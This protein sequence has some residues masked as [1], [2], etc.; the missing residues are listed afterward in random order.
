MEK[1][2]ALLEPELLFTKVYKENRHLPKAARE[3]ACLKVQ[4]KT[5]LR[6]IKPYQKVAGYIKFNDVG[7]YHVM[8]GG[9]TE[10]ID[11]AGFCY[12]KGNILKKLNSGN[13]TTQKKQEVLD[14]CA[15]WDGEYTNFKA[16]QNFTDDM[17]AVA[18]TDK[19]ESESAV[20]HPLYRVAEMQLNWQKLVKFGIGGLKNEVKEKLAVGSCQLSGDFYKELLGVLNLFDEACLFYIE[21]AEAKGRNEIKTALQNIRHNPPETFFEVLQLIWLYSVCAGA[22]DFN[23][24]DVVLGDFYYND[25]QKGTLFEQDAVEM[26][27]SAFRCIQE[28]YGRN[29]RITF[30]GLGRRNEKNADALALVIMEAGRRAHV[31]F[32]QLSLRMYKGMNG[33]L[34]DKALELLS[35]GLTLPVLYNDDKNIG[36]VAKAFEVSQEVATDY[37]FLGCGEYLLAHR[38]IGTPNVII[39]MAK[40]LE[41]VINENAGN[42]NLTFCELWQAYEKKTE[43]F[44]RGAARIQESIYKTLNNEVS[45]LFQSLLMDDCVARGKAVLD[46]GIWHLGGTIETYGNITVSDSLYAIKKAVYK[47]KAITLSELF[48]MLKCNFEGYEKQ[49]QYLLNLHKYG[50]GHSEV[51]AMAAKVHEHMCLL[52]KSQNKNTSLSSFLVVEINNSANVTLG[53]YVGATANGRLAEDCLSNGNN[54]TKGA[55]KNGITALIHSLTKMRGDIHAGITQNFKFSK[56]FFDNDRDNLKTVLKTYFL[57]GG[58]QANINVLNKNDLQNAIKNPA[59]HQNLF[60]RVGGYSARFVDLPSDVQKD[61]IERTLY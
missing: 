15:F 33:K 4:L 50:N 2:Y 11:K 6:G 3:V 36:D 59:E 54:P 18:P 49:R 24:L 41:L 14:M 7:L 39:N 57:M 43:H 26:L 17:A 52:V 38:S 60:V 31:P 32:P 34:F 25:I 21:D 55:D 19:Y 20:V 28:I 5:M 46:G 44:V 13:F 8:Y 10:G 48:A 61:I 12:D 22:P 27:A 35:G 29:S 58:S 40:V 30:G 9:V 51:D 56:Q 23:R 45:F 53:K 37:S 42:E 16:R 1:I 47:D